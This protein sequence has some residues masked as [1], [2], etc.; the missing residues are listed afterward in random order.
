LIESRILTAQ[1]GRG[2]EVVKVRIAYD[3]DP[4]KRYVDRTLIG[5]K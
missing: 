3:K 2:G 1:R 4:V 5:S